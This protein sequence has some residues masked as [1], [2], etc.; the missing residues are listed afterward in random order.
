MLEISYFKLQLINLSLF[1][2]LFQIIS[3]LKEKLTNFELQYQNT[4]GT[5]QQ[6]LTEMIIQI[7]ELKLQLSDESRKSSETQNL[8][9]IQLDNTLLSNQTIN[10]KL[11]LEKKEVNYPYIISVNSSCT[12]YCSQILS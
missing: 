6:Q 1:F 3:D 9:R 8:L 11:S 10:E 5:H 2:F 4:Q 7:D 12:A